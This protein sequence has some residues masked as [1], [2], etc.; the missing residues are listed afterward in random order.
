ML[1]RLRPKWQST[2][3]DVR[4]QAVREL[5]KGEVELLTAVAQQDPDPRVRRIAVKKLESPRLLL[6]LAEKDEDAGLRSFALKRARQI[7]VHI[8]CDRRDVEESRRAL[9]LLLEPSDRVTVME[10]AH[11]AELRSAAFEVLTDDEALVEVVRRARDP[12]LRSGALDKIRAPQ[13]LKKVI[14]DESSGDLALLAL[15][16]VEDLDTLEAIFE[17]HTLPRTVR[18]Q[19]FT[20]LERLVPA[21]HP[22]KAR[23]RRESYAEICAR[24]E[25]LA[26]S[27][28]P[29]A[30]L[31]LPSLRR[32][33]SEI[34]LGGPPDAKLLSRYRAALEGIEALGEA[35]KAARPAEAPPAA[36]TPAPAEDEREPALIELVER[37]ERLE[38][39]SLE[40]GIDEARKAWRDIA[41]ERPVAP[42]LRSR[43]TRAERAAGARLREWNERR[44]RIDDLEEL[45]RR[46][47]TASREP[48]LKTAAA[49]LHGLERAWNRATESER[50]DPALLERLRSALTEIES[51]EQAERR[52]REAAERAALS[53][54]EARIQL[55]TSLA[56]AETVSIKDADRA[57]REA[58]EFLRSMGPLPREVNRRKARRRLL[59]AREALF[60]RTQDTRELEEWKRWANV[61]VQAGLIERVEKLLQSNDLPRVA[62]EMRLIHEE[63]RK[64]GAATPDKAPELWNRY[65]TMRDE[66]KARCD[67]FF[68]KQTRERAETLKKKEELCAQVEAIQDSQ[69]WSRTAE[70]IQEIQLR[71]KKLGPVP[72]ESSDAIWKR[73]RA[74]CDHFFDRRKRSFRRLKAERD[75]NLARKQAL[76]ERAEALM[77]STD[78]E[79]SADEVKS[80]QAQWRDIGAVP[81]KNSDEIWMRFRAACDRFFDRYK[82]RDQVENEERLRR[83]EELIE[84][85]GGFGGQDESSAGSMALRVQEIWAEW[86]KLGAPPDEN[87]DLRE[88]FE[89]EVGRLVLLAPEV[90]AGSELDP[91]ASAKRR[92][93]F[94]ARLE[95]ILGELDPSK[96]ETP[97]LESLAERLKD[98]LASN[99]IGGV[100]RHDP[101]LDWR[102]ASEEV[103]RLRA[104]WTRSAPVPGEKGRALAERFEQAVR[105]FSELRPSDPRS[106]RRRDGAA[107]P[108]R[109]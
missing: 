86:K 6:E 21:D 31:E 80:L 24:A 18:R 30:A 93:K 74:A 90:F 65:K 60:K 109:A 14:L 52:E 12:E 7:L 27:R 58:Q 68:E 56:G 33:W 75:E 77:M 19:A 67:A 82:R 20:K 8:A 76:C 95:A 4:A 107:A 3:A 61:E 9:A 94:C 108:T 50:A 41:G 63:W 99:T 45:V 89:S 84:E 71:W 48:D 81:R 54:L 37:V 46:A 32:E 62:K 59:L 55:M 10:K 40:A 96:P 1:D 38:G 2:D 5:D 29:S 51:R 22:I 28:L 104:S 26:D 106:H 15:S 57:L 78:W 64:A 103:T 25:T 17:Q 43:F 97:P 16:R 83:R 11:F 44:A 105:S 101:R 72:P 73:F 47:E 34:E 85:L 13:A 35:A 69:D 92:E 36:E 23:A 42:R 87:R 49:T 66:L 70:A 100:R 98:A 88:R 102:A 79:R 91:A 53:E 39:D